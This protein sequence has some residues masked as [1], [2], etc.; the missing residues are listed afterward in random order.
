MFQTHFYVLGDFGPGCLFVGLVQGNYYTRMIYSPSGTIQPNVWQHVAMTFDRAS[1]EVVLYRNGQV[2]AQGS[3]SGMV[4]ETSSD[5]YIGTRPGWDGPFNYE[6]SMDEVSLYNR[7]LTASEITSIY[8]ASSLGKVPP[9]G[10]PVITRQPV[11]RTVLTGANFV[12][13]IGATG[14]LPLSYQWLFN[15][16]P[17]EGATG[18]ALTLSN[19]QTNQSGAYSVIVSNSVGSATSTEALLTVNPP[20]AITPG[21]GLVSWWAG[22]NN[23]TDTVGGNNGTALGNVNYAPGQV[24]QG[25]LLNGTNSGVKIP[26]HPS[27]NVGLGEG[28]TMETWINPARVSGRQ[29]L[30][31]WYDTEHQ[32]FGTQF[33]VLGDFGAGTLFAGLV[34]ASGSSHMVYSAPGVIEANTWQH[35][36][37]TY[38]KASG[39]VV[40]Y[41]NGVPVARRTVGSFVPQTTYDFY[42]GTRPGW[43]GPFYYEGVLDEMGLYNRALSSGEIA[44][45]Y[46]ASSAGKNQSVPPL[47]T[48]QPQSQIILAGD[49]ASFSVGVSGTGP[50]YYQ[51]QFNGVDILGA[52]E[53][54]L[55]LTDVGVE[56]AGTYS[57]RVTNAFGSVTSTGATLSVVNEIL[58]PP[59]IT[60]QPHGQMVSVGATVTFSVTASGSAPLGYQWRFNGAEVSGATNS[61]LILTA[62]QATQA[63]SYSVKVSNPAGFTNSASVTLTVYVPSGGGTL[64]FITRDTLD[65]LDAP[66]SFSG[67]GPAPTGRINGSNAIPTGD[68][69][70]GG[71]NARAG[72]YAG[73]AGSTEEQLTLL[74]PIVGF[75]GGVAAGY[76]APGI[77]SSRTVPGVE[78]GAPA[79]AQVRVWD[80][81]VPDMATYEDA[82]ALAHTRGVYLGKSALVNIPA[83]G[84]GGMPPSVPAPLIGLTAFN[85]VY[86]DMS[87]QMSAAPLSLA[88]MYNV[89]QA[90]RQQPIRLSLKLNEDGPGIRLEFQGIMGQTYSIQGSG[91]LVDWVT[92][93]TC[94]TSIDGSAFFDDST[95]GNTVNRFYRLVVP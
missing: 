9:S 69:V 47:I 19:V 16:V 82:V 95:A 66:A 48:M 26:A 81:G 93:G 67:D 12:F 8:Q 88:Q 43:D 91:N 40:L 68:Y 94:T 53:P 17:I 56:Q 1:G 90:A 37:M 59:S 42:L 57:V 32:M 29:P 24:G 61:T 2:V 14:G 74:A 64:M 92:I 45:I 58:I 89:Y 52:T 30:A 35:V 63:G 28:Y 36:A 23:T 73:P 62:V 79:V 77:S 20:G 70:W 84:G 65:A 22:E 85:A 11:A 38:D 21:A 50:L 34:Q 18:A 71:L 51:W 10:P 3:A 6:G 49:N 7:A 60:S 46:E 86:T 75:R 13:N 31:E 39:V 72:L 55:G 83:L 5:F 44:A 27:L 33:Y 87:V 80:A 54:A 78:P 76:V 15:G 41:R 25:F 4:L